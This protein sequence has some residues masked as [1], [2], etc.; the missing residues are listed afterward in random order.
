[1]GDSGIGHSDQFAQLG[2]GVAAKAAGASTRA[3]F[4]QELCQE[5][6]DAILITGD[7]TNAANLKTEL[8]CLAQLDRPVYFI[9]GNHDFYGGTI[10]GSSDIAKKVAKDYRERLIYLDDTWIVRLTNTATLIG[11]NGFGDGLAGKG[12]KTRARMNDFFH[13]QNFASLQN[14]SGRF[15]LMRTLA[16]NATKK[17]ERKLLAAAPDSDRVVIA[18]HVPPFIESSFHEGKIGSAE[19]LPFF[20][21][22]TMGR[23]LLDIAERFP[24]VEF[25]VFAGHTHS[26]AP[27]YRPVQNLTVTVDGAEYGN[28]KISRVL[29]FV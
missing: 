19:Y 8:E 20:A 1:L 23:M 2:Q 21:C 15:N 13:I 3:R 11:V 28:P 16:E 17:L 9:L 6:A 10:T 4:L 24:K 29:E 26:P 27:V 18:T 12:S 14:D 22:P 5:P 25:E 7:I